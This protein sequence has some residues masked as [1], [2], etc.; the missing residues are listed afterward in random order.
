M[1]FITS[2]FLKMQETISYIQAGVSCPVRNRVMKTAPKMQA[3]LIM[4][5][6]WTW[7]F[8]DEAAL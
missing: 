2:S 8:S 1:A 3:V 7:Y 5:G 4:H 6:V